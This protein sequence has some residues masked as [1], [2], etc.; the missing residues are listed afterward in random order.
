MSN[1]YYP[2]PSS[3]L[4]PPHIAATLLERLTLCNIQPDFRLEPH[5]TDCVLFTEAELE[6]AL[7]GRKDT[8]TGL[9]QISYSMLINLPQG[10]K[11]FLLNIYNR[12]LQ[13][14]SLP[15]AWKSILIHPILKSDKNP[16]IP[17]SYRPIALSSCVGKI[18]ETML[19]NR[20]E[21]FV[22]NSRLLSDLQTAFRKG[23]SVAD[24]V[25]YLT[26]FVQ[27][28]FSRNHC[29]LGIVLDI[30]SAFDNVNIFTLYRI[31][32]GINLPIP[33]CNLTFNI[34]NNRKIYIKDLYGNIHGPETAT[35]GLSQGSS[36][37]PLLFNI[38]LH[39]LRHAI[40][41]YA[42]ISQYADD[43]LIL[44]TGPDELRLIEQAK[45]ILGNLSTSLTELNL[46]VSYSK[47]AAIMFRKSN[48]QRN[49]PC[50]VMDGD[51]IPWKQQVRYLGVM[52]QNTLKWN[53]QIDN[54]CNKAQKSLNILRAAGGTKWGADPLILRSVYFGIVRSHLEYCCQVYQPI[55][56][57]L[58]TKMDKIQYQSLRIIL[59]CMKSTPTNAL[60]AEAADPSLDY[61][62]KWLS[63][64]YITKISKIIDHPL[65]EVLTDLSDYCFSGHSYWAGKDIPYLV[66]ALRIVKRYMPHLFS[67]P[68]FPCFQFSLGYQITQLN[69]FPCN[70][71]KDVDNKTAFD[72]LAKENWIGYT[73][74]FTDASR[75]SDGQKTGIGLFVPSLNHTYSARLKPYNQ[76][77]AAEITAIYK[78]C[79][80]A[81]DNKL[82]K[83]VI[84]SD[85]KAALQLIT[86]AS[87][88]EG[89]LQ[90]TLSTKNSS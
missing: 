2:P 44:L 82:E 26:S 14:S 79:R 90:I 47:S 19:K 39:N 38:Y 85:S 57:Y 4:P 56:N 27:L 62:R 9:D 10:A 34:T 69:Y 23:R 48:R 24:N 1:Y 33:L 3:K 52:F 41:R 31:L 89:N 28:G 63:V 78:A 45:D 43:L 75:V 84:C 35:Q 7:S 6:Y 5:D 65:L 29:T 17:E 58:K 42:R 37:S 77:Y 64:K 46:S 73:M 83:V 32:V 20:I 88:N 60:T 76:I 8:A 86:K 72:N 49:L 18:L 70:L 53:V 12:C 30:K 87:Y 15:D 61:R 74:I 59:G 66:Y 40:P 80:F 67:F 36:L 50:I 81:V 16:E 68:T 55:P 71:K 11:T 13:G 25:T 54:V 51:I 22:E 21:W